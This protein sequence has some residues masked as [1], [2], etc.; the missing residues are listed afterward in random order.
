M[1]GGRESRCVGRVYGVDGSVRLARHHLSKI[2]V[3][4]TVCCNSTSN[5]PDDVRMYPKHV[6]LSLR[7]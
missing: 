2:S 4:K 6:E 5:A 7:Q 1:G 3:Q